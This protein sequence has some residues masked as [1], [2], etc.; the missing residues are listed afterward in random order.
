MAFAP[1]RWF[2][3]IRNVFSSIKKMVIHASSEYEGDNMEQHW[4]SEALLDI[5]RYLAPEKLEF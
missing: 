4:Y 2:N 3:D 1:A 5:G